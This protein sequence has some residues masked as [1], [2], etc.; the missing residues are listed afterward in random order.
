MENNN[1]YE[2]EILVIRTIQTAAIRILI[3]ALKEILTDTNLIFDKSGI[4]IMT[5]D[6]TK[7]V[8]IHMKLES[9]K[10]EEFYCQKEIKCGISMM[11][12]YKLI[13]TIRENLWKN[14]N[15]YSVLKK[16]KEREKRLTL[17]KR[18]TK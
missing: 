18:S 1:T 4:K 9:D 13:K 11:N 14:S 15:V 7:T 12:L 3:E 5:T 16:Y 8:L 17:R 2:N 6:S 10:F